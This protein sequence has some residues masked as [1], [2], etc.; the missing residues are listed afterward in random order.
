MTA[1]GGYQGSL[2]LLRRVEF[3]GLTMLWRHEACE[4][5]VKRQQPPAEVP[6]ASG[7]QAARPS[8]RWLRV[9]IV[10]LITLVV[11]Y[12]VWWFY[13]ITWTTTTTERHP[14]GIEIR[15]THL[16]EFAPYIGFADNDSRVVLPIPYHHVNETEER[17]LLVNGAVL[18]T[19][20]GMDFADMRPSPAGTYVVVEHFVH[21]QPIRVYCATTGKHV[22]L[23]VPEDSH[24]EFPGHHNVY[25]F[26]F[27]RWESDSSFL[28]EVTGNDFSSP[29]LSH[30]RQVWRV[31]AKTGARSRIE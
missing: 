6:P 18:L 26:R 16:H 13:P 1:G 4:P 19:T 28:V 25:P 17:T 5:P 23:A 30:Y 22:E 20:R 14:G 15:T 29:G 10:G 9:L 24:E 7:T 3:G 21:T 12:V 31:D 11:L 27:L 8:R 2:C